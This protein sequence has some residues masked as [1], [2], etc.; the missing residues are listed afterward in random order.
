MPFAILKFT[1]A[2]KMCLLRVCPK[3]ACV[4]D[5]AREGEKK[6]EREGKRERE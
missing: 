1:F 5:R 6:I 4:C 3:C 2:Q